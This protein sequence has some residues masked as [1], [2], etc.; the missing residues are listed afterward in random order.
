MGRRVASCKKYVTAG[1]GA[2]VKSHDS[3][4]QQTWGNRAV[5]AT[6]ISFEGA[7]PSLRAVVAEAERLGEMQIDIL[8]ADEHSLLVAFSAF[9]GAHVTIVAIP[10]SRQISITDHLSAAPFLT[11]LLR[12]A[13]MR[14]G[15]SGHIEHDTGIHL[16]VPITEAFVNRFMRQHQWLRTLLWLAMPLLFGAAVVAF[17]WLVWELLH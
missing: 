2:A 10:D 13:S 4:W 3:G 11:R 8:E 1:C 14:L 16:A 12:Q 15:G 6:V 7:V 17:G 5:E 9:P